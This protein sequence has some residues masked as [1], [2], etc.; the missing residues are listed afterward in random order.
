MATIVGV[1][2]DGGVVLAGDRRLTRGGTVSSERK[3]HVFDFGAVGAA[4][5]GEAG[6]IDEFRRQLD[7]EVRSH[8]TEQG[9]PM[10]IDRFASVA[11]DLAAAEGVEAVVAARDDGVPR[12]RGISSDGG[13]ITDDA[14]AFGSGAQ[15]ALGVLEGR[16]AGLGVDDAEELVRDAVETTAD[17]DT[18]TG[19]EIDTYRL[20]A[21]ADS[22]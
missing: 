18:D 2:V 21:D 17:R 4:A 11:S 3:R 7:S 8:E 12:V 20:P 1:A 19:A 16:E 9:D 5:V 6:G 22:A 10:G 14:V 13:V 15:L